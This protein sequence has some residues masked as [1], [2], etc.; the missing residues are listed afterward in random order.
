MRKLELVD[1][2][3]YNVLKTLL[4]DR[5]NELTD[6]LRALRETLPDEL[7]DVKDPE[8]LCV[9]EFVHGLDFAL[10]EM[11]SRTLARIN[12]AMTRLESGEYG[13]CLDCSDAISNARLQALPFADRCRDCQQSREELAADTARQ[14]SRFELPKLDAQ[15]TDAPPQAAAAPGRPARD[16]T[17][18]APARAAMRKALPGQLAL[19]KQV[20][21]M[22]RASALPRPQAPANTSKPAADR[23][24]PRSVAG[25]AAGRRVVTRNKPA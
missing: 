16:F 19:R 1:R 6:K 8:E 17:R 2:E 7:A 11:K 23:S 22:E 13:T 25:R 4:Q 12:D 9:Q 18:R 24:R 14:Q 21:G 3:R 10:I 20:A 15:P 5:A